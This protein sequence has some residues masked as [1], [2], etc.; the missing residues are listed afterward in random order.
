VELEALNALFVIGRSI[1]IVGHIMD[2]RRMKQG[3]YRHPYDDILNT[4]PDRP[5]EV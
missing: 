2:Q 5:I 1:G 3:L 4:M